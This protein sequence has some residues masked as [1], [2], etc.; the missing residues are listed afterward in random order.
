MTFH[1]VQSDEE[2]KAVAK[3]ARQVFG[4]FIALFVQNNPKWAFY[5]RNDEGEMVGGV[6]LKRLG[7]HVGI[8]DFIFVSKAG[9]GQGVGPQLLD[10]GLAAIEAAGCKQQLALVRDDNTPSWNMFAT[11]GFKIPNIFRAFFAYGPRAF[12]YLF[13]V[14]FANHGYS[15]WAKETGTNETARP[16]TP[17][18][19]LAAIILLSLSVA[20]LMGLGIDVSAFLPY[21]LPMVFGV[22]ILRLVLTWPFARSYGPLRFQVPHGGVPLSLFLGFLGAWWPVL[23]MWV[24]RDPLW[25]ESKFRTASG[26]AS[27]A[28]WLTTIAALV[29]TYYVAPSPNIAEAW[30]GSLVPMLFYQAVPIGPFEGLDGFRVLKWSKTAFVLGLVLSIAVFVFGSIL[31]MLG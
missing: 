1:E 25:H 22:T 30:Q 21:A 13:F 16:V 27:F 10:R 9:R 8:I 24:P 7:K 19:G 11:R 18:L 12:L 14:L 17:G 4:F 15:V 6:I 20:G 29:A 5:A 23:G 26:M 2:G 3:L 28:G 31:G